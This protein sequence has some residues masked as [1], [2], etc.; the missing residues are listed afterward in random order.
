MTSLDVQVVDVGKCSAKPVPSG[1]FV[2]FDAE[3]C[4]HMARLLGWV[5]LAYGPGEKMGVSGIDCPGPDFAGV[6]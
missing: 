3:E 5:L 1:D 2:Y 6:R 4:V